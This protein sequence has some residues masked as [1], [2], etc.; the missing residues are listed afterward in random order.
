MESILSSPLFGLALCIAAYGVGYLI[1]KKIRSPLVNPLVIGAAIIILLLLYTPLT[2]EQFQQGG[3]MIT[4]FIF[5]ATVSLGLQVYRQWQA[6]RQNILPLLAGCLA[7]SV[8]SIVSVYGMCRLFRIDEILTA[9]LLPKSVTSAIAAE[10]AGKIGGLEALA[11]SAVVFTGIL[12]AV[13][14]PLLIKA[15]RLK[16]PAA[17]GIGLGTS[18]H[19]AGTAKAIE[20]GELQGAMSSISL[21][22]SGVITSLIFIFIG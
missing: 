7:G 14:S 2:M 18:G 16:D 21:S 1:Q 11:I 17:A 19:A 9:S 8:T 3:S 15:L 10:L 20:L 13:I 22:L 12:S 4:L 5:P 6:L